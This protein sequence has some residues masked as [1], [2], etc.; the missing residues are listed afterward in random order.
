[1][2]KKLVLKVTFVAVVPRKGRKKTESFKE[3]LAG[4]Q[5]KWCLVYYNSLMGEERRKRQ[6]L[7]Q[8]KGSRRSVLRV[9][10][11]GTDVLQFVCYHKSH[12]GCC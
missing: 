1:M 2:H 4:K 7:I 5:L 10:Q 3:I 6:P 9:G 12:R 11:M 8:S